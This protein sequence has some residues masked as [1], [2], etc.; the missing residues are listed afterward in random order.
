MKQ[1]TRKNR[2]DSERHTSEQFGECLAIAARGVL[3]QSR[4]LKT[5][6][7][8]SKT[9]PEWELHWQHS[10]IILRK[11][12]HV[13]HKVDCS[14]S[15]YISAA[16]SEAYAEWS[17]KK[18]PRFSWFDWINEERNMI[19]KENS[20]TVVYDEENDSSKFSEPYVL[21]NGEF[22]PGSVLIGR[23][24]R[25]WMTEIEKIEI[26]ARFRKRNARRQSHDARFS[27]R[28]SKQSRQGEN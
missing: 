15:Q 9:L 28:Q 19:L 12:G 27:L 13:L 23:F 26:D 4:R 18:N 24:Q 17:N 22:E 14:R 5:L 10:V 1:R 16:V 21:L 6:L 25:I 2:R 7:K 3:S 11:V 20:Q 8:E